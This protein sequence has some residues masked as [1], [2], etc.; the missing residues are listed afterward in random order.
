MFFAWKRHMIKQFD[1]RPLNAV[2]QL[3]FHQQLIFLEHSCFFE[4]Y[5]FR[6]TTKLI[7]IFNAVA[8]DYQYETKNRQ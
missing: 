3:L 1:S 2:N 5:N 4:T 6:I 8:V 7:V